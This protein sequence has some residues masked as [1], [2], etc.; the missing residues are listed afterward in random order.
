MRSA[1]AMRRHPFLPTLVACLVAAPAL[2]AKPVFSSAP[3]ARFEDAASLAGARPIVASDIAGQATLSSFTVED[4]M[5]VIKGTLDLDNGSR[6]STLGAEIAPADVDAGADMQG[7]S[8]L[9][10]RLAAAVAR[11][12]RVR[13]KGSDSAIGNT[14]CYPVVVQMVTP[15]PADYVIPLA[16]FR[17]PGWCGA[18]APSIEQVLGAV[19]RVEVTANDAPVGAVAFSV[20]KIDFLGGDWNVPA[21]PSR[22][23]E[24]PDLAQATAPSSTAP[25]PAAGGAPRRRLVANAQA[26][27]ASAVAP[28]R[29]VTCEFNARYALMLCY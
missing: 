23:E 14:G 2:L 25:V 22:R 5:L 21:S 8:V 4:A 3:W 9:R 24:P 20:G 13:I 6:W 28:A 27:G 18:R 12:L 10:I 1:R 19:Q 11:P 7:A 16:A 15:V 26:T 17:A 29:R